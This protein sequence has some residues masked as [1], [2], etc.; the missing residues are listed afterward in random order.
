MSKKRRCIALNYEHEDCL[1]PEKCY[2]PCEHNKGYLQIVRINESLEAELE[3]LQKVQ[4]LDSDN[5]FKR[6]NVISEE[7]SKL[8][9]ENAK[10]KEVVE[11]IKR[12]I[13]NHKDM[14]NYRGVEVGQSN[15][16]GKVIEV[17]EEALKG[18]E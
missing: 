15:V 16:D 9:A 8:E 5:F 1:M 10:L 4:K 13:V 17:I 18:M 11:T 14:C 12:I 7:Y 2:L 3:N 6:L